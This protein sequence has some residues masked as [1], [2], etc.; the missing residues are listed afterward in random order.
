MSLREQ[1]EAAV[2]K[3]MKESGFLEVEIRVECLGRSGDGYIDASIDAYWHFWQQAIT[4]VTH[5]AVTGQSQIDWLQEVNTL[6]RQVSI[7]YVVD[8]YEVTVT[9]DDN[10]ISDDFH[11]ET[12]SEAI[13]NAMAGFDLE[14]KPKWLDKDIHGHERQMAALAAQRDEALAALEGMLGKAYKQNW[15]DAYPEVLEGAE[16]IIAKAKRGVTP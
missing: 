14:A 15:N 9:W 6:H 5:Q 4:T 10:P 16:A 13:S 11:G 8:G 7:L 1:F 2:I 12:V 3:R